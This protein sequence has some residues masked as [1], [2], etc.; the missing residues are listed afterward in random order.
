MSKLTAPLEAFPSLLLD[1]PKKK[2]GVNLNLSTL[3]KT[4]LSCRRQ[5]HAVNKLNDDEK[6]V[7]LIS[8]AFIRNI[9]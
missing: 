5:K 3:G 4:I 6:V 9:I 7:D 2:K 1:A 8:H